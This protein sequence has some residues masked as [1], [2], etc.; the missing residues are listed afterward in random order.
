MNIL[1][2]L[3][4]RPLRAALAAAL[5]VGLP[6]A[7][8]TAP[9]SPA[10]AQ[11]DD[12][13]RAVTALRG[14]STMKA[15]FTQTDRQGQVARGVMTLKRPG[16]IRFE[17]EKSI[18]MLVVSNGK[19]LYMIDYEVDQVQRWPIRRS[20]L[21]A[22]LDPN[23]DVKKYGK[24]IP[25]SNP[26]VVSIEVRDSSRPEFGVITMIFVRSSSAP[27]GLQLTNWVALDSQNHRTTVKLRNHRYGVAVSDSA[28]TFKDPRR[29]SRRPR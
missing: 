17:Y 6:V 19:S 7:A 8:L 28:F 12:L 23:R 24:L 2:S 14:I 22:L 20:P 4:Q 18:P 16:K 13:D 21:G 27:G 10:A 5:A 9:A 11:Q 1:H 15:D 3:T 25:T 26:D 29:T